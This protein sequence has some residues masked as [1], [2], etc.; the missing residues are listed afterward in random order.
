VNRMRLRSLLS[1]WSLRL[2]PLALALAVGLGVS[3]AA[4]AAPGQGTGDPSITTT[5]LPSG[6]VGTSYS[7]AVDVVGTFPPFTWLV[8]SG[9]LPPGLSLPT[10]TSGSGTISGTPTN[11]GTYDFTL[12]VTD[13]IGDSASQAL[14]ITI[15]Q[16]GTPLTVDTTSL[17]PGAVTAP[18][19]QALGVSGG[20]GPYAWSVVPGTL[21][22]GLSL[23][24]TGTISGTPTAS[25]SYAFTVT[26][27]D[28]TG[29]T[30]TK[31]LSITVSDPQLMITTT[32][33]PSGTVGTSYSQAVDVDG[34]FPPFVWSVVSGSLPPGLSLPTATAGNGTISGTPT[35]AGTY[36][37]TVQV[38]DVIGDM[39]DQALS[40][41]IGQPAVPLAVTT[42]SLPGATVGEAYSQ[43][44]AASGGTSPYTWSVQGGSLPSGLALSNS[45]TISGTPTAAGTYSFTVRVT[46]AAGATAPRA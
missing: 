27:A 14:S 10:A 29:A 4:N 25:G 20:T 38:T 43:A 34:V 30:A 22:P 3:G 19:R 9:S 7:Q 21:P 2:L 16:P 37:F 17:P 36:S 26:V 33:L 44:L 24:A 42:V 15:S 6:A 32:S 41:T 46:D 1:R 13:V 45:G 28:A 12:Q 18:Y 40:I 11:A 23:S 35:T 8:E 39:S 31:A 5:S